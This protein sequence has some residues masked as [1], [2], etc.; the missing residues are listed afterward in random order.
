MFD[1]AVNSFFSSLQS[2]SLGAEGAQYVA[3]ALKVNTCILELE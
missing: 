1:E 2:N 3:E